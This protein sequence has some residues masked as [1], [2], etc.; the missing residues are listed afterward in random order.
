MGMGNITLQRAFP[1]PSPQ[2]LRFP[3]AP[4]EIFLRDKEGRQTPGMR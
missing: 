3:F 1:V 2:R 4:K